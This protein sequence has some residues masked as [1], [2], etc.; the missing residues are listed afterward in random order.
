MRLVTT[1]LNTYPDSSDLLT[2]V[3]N[4]FWNET[5]LLNVTLQFEHCFI[6]S[7]DLSITLRRSFIKDSTNFVFRDV[8]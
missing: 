4:L 5:I 3:I 1:N 2:V 7:T 6:S 8:L